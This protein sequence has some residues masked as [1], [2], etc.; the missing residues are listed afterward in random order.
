M[1]EST[2]MPPIPMADEARRLEVLASYAVMDTPPDPILDGIVRVASRLVG[3]PIG[4]VSLLDDH[5]QW[6][7]ARTGLAV[8]ETPRDI[9]FC[10]IVVR[11][12][13]ELVVEDAQQD[14]RFVRNPLVA[15]EPHVRFYVGMPLRVPEGEVLGT[16]CAI[17]TMPQSLDEEKRQQLRELAEV[18]TARLV[19]LRDEAR[20]LK[21]KSE[22]LTHHRFF[23]KSLD[24]FCVVCKE[25][26]FLEL[27]SRWVQVLGWPEADML[28]R[29]FLDFV[30]PDDMAS[31]L[32]IWTALEGRQDVLR[33][34]N[35]YRRANGSHAWLEWNALAPTA[36]E[37]RVFA[38]AR[39]VTALVESD[40]ALRQQNA[41][42]SLIS[43]SQ[44]R[45]ARE[46]AS[47]AWWTYVLQ[48]LLAI[49]GSEYGFIGETGIDAEGK[50]LRTK[51][52]TNIAWNE[53][54]KAF[55][56]ANAPAGMYFRNL[57][58][59]FGISIDHET[60]VIANDVTHDPRAGGR[61]PGH[62]PLLTY[63]GLP[64][65]EGDQMIG[66]VGLAN[67][68]GGFHED[69]LDP[70]EPVLAFLA[71]AMRTVRL[72]DDRRA[73][74]RQ[75]EIATDLQKRVLQY[76][77][78]AFIALRDDGSVALVNDSA[79]ELL[80]EVADIATG[81]LEQTLAALF[82]PEVHGAW[83]N[84]LLA[85]PA[86]LRLPGRQIL[87]AG[88]APIEVQ[89]TRLPD[90]HGEQPGLLLA[91]NDLRE[92]DALRQSIQANAVL[93][94]RVIQLRSQQQH[95]QL[96]SECVEYLQGCTSLEE[97]LELVGRSL[98]RLFP[99]ANVALFGTTSGTSTMPLLRHAKRFGKNAPLD[100]IAASQ[101]WA[102]RSRRAYGSWTG[103]H[104]LPCSHVGH[105]QTG[106]AYCVPLF[107]LDRNVA[108]FLVDF[109][110]EGVHDDPQGN[111]AR[112]AQF[113]AMGQSISGA[114]STIALR[115]SLQ[116]MALTDELTTLPNRRAFYD[117]VARGITRARRTGSP[118]AMAILDID[119]FKS[120]NDTYGHDAGDQ[121]LR[122]IAQVMRR[123]LREGDLV[124]RVGGEEFG[125]FL[126]DVTG[127]AAQQRLERL[128]SSIRAACS[129]DGKPITASI[130]LAHASDAPVSARFDDLYRQA[131]E[132]LY[133]AKGG[134]RNQVV[135]STDQPTTESPAPKA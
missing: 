101:C 7:K 113:V 110:D 94:E 65:R 109:P 127:E 99:T 14:P 117:E 23:E 69:I 103:G 43:Q 61:P 19:A 96:L 115:E 48:E 114:L 98:E 125:L 90:A 25:G 130:G 126:P 31:T 44:A 57:K 95:N 58:T 120:I 64:L 11:S 29:P 6:F 92:R 70:L 132:A 54:T 5:R 73:F 74:V 78:S 15:G 124:A 17:D 59:L 1:A 122:D 52:I 82:P 93:E 100:E 51:A 116:R 72:E 121:V 47:L 105:E 87:L 80:P 119:H 102:L 38:T 84:A 91:I 79:L 83:I 9:A 3:V 12:G 106:A 41:L 112:L 134:G 129:M 50:F 18:A 39:D 36:T 135:R 2:P 4:L 76:S 56:A 62:P 22:L 49:T 8:E 118:F 46:G 123:S 45:F 28:G 40:N 81:S 26:R 24:L 21:S 88:H 35:R 42:L 128:L 27:N 97:G 107:S 20:L 104:H 16:L 13:E 77:E 86:G 60:R 32:A 68:S 71:S 108:V 66:L 33:F 63:A 34:R 53:E 55:Y 133:R 10:D 89:A 37:E 67:R 131:D 30:H 85:L 75:L 111:E